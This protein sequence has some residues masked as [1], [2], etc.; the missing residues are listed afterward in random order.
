MACAEFRVKL[1]R[2]GPWYPVEILWKFTLRGWSHVQISGCDAHWQVWD[3]YGS[4]VA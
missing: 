4:V 3:T 1:L 2:A